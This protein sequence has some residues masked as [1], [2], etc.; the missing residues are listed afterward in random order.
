MKKNNKHI[1]TNT[2]KAN[3]N[4]N[5]IIHLK[6]RDYPIIIG[7]QGNTPLVSINYPSFLRMATLYT[8]MTGSPTIEQKIMAYM[9]CN[10]VNGYF[11]VDRGCFSMMSEGLQECRKRCIRAIE[12]MVSEGLLQRGLTVDNDV[13]YLLPEFMRNISGASGRYL[14]GVEVIFE[15]SMSNL[16]EGAILNDE[17][18]P[19]GGLW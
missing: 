6:L 10:Q 3:P 1:A 5:T 19:M 4:N 11:R 12:R 2:N 8:T 7:S 17:Y 14:V 18:I 9:G 15:K 13:V 16:G